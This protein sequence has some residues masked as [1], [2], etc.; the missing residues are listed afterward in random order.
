MRPLPLL[1]VLLSA[2]LAAV[3]ASAADLPT[4]TPEEVGLSS[5]RLARITETLRADVEAGRI[6][7]AVV[8]V[9]RK[10]RIAYA[11]AVGFRDKAAGSRMT[12]DSNFRIASM[13]KPMVSV[14]TMMLYEDGRLFVSDPISKYIP[15]LGKMQVGVERIDPM[16]G[17]SVLA[18]VPADREMTIQDLLRHTSGLTYG[19]RG[20]TLIHQ[21]YPTSS[22]AA[23]REITSEEFI[24]RLSKAPLLF[25]PGTK[26]EYSF[27]SDVLG[28]VVEVVSGKSLGVF[29]AERIFQPLA[30]SDTAFWVPAAK[31]ERLA[32]PLA[33]DPDTGKPVSVP[34]VTVAPKFECGGGCAVATAGDYVRFA[35]MMLNRG[36]LDGT[37]LLGRKT[38]EYMTSDHLGT[39]TGAG[40]YLP[41]PG[42]GFGLGFAVRRE[43][44][45]ANLTG[46]SGDY[47]WGGAYGTAFWVDPKE[48]LVV[49]SMTQAPGAIRVHYR[50]LLKS[51]VLQAITD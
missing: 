3:A 21:A 9:A 16:T 1:F 51:F 26:W 35:Q 33:T 19:N 7:G 30:M 22:S 34:D 40:D 23:S 18:L 43:T 45:L 27:S 31:R 6:P 4:A 12:M 50:Q 20:T 36:S 10:G 39:I 37:R 17:K 46:T 14:A 32:Q 47:N 11:E 49:V 41:G 2:V 28:R 24:A 29:L 5:S 8:I 42:Y 38:V 25:S 48:Q 13:T 44:G 15:A